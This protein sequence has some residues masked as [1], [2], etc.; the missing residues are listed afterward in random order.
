MPELTVGSCRLFYRI[1][2]KADPDSLPVVCIHGAGGSSHVWHN[3]LS[4]PITGYAPMALDLPGHARSHG[5]GETSIQAYSKWIIDFLRQLGCG[6]SVLVGHS[7]GGAITLDVALTEP[8]MLKAIILVGTGARLRV[9]QEVL[10]Q[11]RKGASLTEYAY[12]PETPLSVIQE[13]EKEFDLTSPDIRYNDFVAC[14][15]FDAMQRLSDI[16]CPALVICGEQDRLTPVKYSQYLHR[17]IPGSRLEIIPQAGH[18]VM[19]EQ[20]GACNRAIQDFVA[21]LV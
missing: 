9:T 20:A 3:Q 4:M 13:A 14:D 18:M 10:D 16:Q 17:H 19:W 5:S 11:A 1:S 12:T 7:M 6:Q 8:D 2:P 21:K 15:G